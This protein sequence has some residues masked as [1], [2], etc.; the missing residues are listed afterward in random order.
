[1]RACFILR[2]IRI[3]P[4]TNAIPLM[5]PN[6]RSGVFLGT[7]KADRTIP[8]SIQISRKMIVFF[9]IRT[10]WNSTIATALLTPNRVLRSGVHQC[11]EAP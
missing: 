5:I 8:R 4:S 11:S 10:L 3:F 2:K 1:V 9:F 7:V 6:V